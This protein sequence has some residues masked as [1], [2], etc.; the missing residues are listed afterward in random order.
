MGGLLCFGEAKAEE[1]KEV[2][3]APRPEIE[4]VDIVKMKLKQARDRIKNFVGAKN[5]DL[6]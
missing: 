5:K 1:K 3:E 4:K 6:N 2:Q